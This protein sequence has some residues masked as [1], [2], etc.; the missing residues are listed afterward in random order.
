MACIIEP[1]FAT[2]PAGILYAKPCWPRGIGGG[3]TILGAAT[4]NETACHLPV[5]WHVSGHAWPVPTAGPSTP[6]NALPG[7]SADLRLRRYSIRVVAEMRRAR[8]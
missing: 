2:S 4:P 6:L 1:A 5:A 8:S 7:A 3:S